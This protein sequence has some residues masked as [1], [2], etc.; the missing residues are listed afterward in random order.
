MKTKVQFYVEPGVAKDVLA[1]FPDERRRDYMP[2]GGKPDVLVTCYS[3]V[4]QHSACSAEYLKGLRRATPGEY[5]RL[6]KELAS[7][8]YFLDVEGENPIAGAAK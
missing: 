7:I 5:A 1:V 2:G 6:A 3:H 4:G 8:G